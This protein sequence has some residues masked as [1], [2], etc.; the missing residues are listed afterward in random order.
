MAAGYMVY[1]WVIGWYGEKRDS[2][3]LFVLDNIPGKVIFD[4]YLRNSFFFI[5]TNDI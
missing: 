4:R 1:L 3:N 5:C 2:R